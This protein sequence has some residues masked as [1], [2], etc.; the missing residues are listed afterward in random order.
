MGASTNGGLYKSGRSWRRSFQEGRVPHFADEPPSPPVPSSQSRPSESGPASSGAAAVSGASRRL[1][2]LADL[3]GSLTDALGPEEAAN[4]VEQK[5]LS[6]L[7]A[8]S[9]VVVTLGAF[10]PSPTTVPAHPALHVVHAIGLPA[11]IGA[12]LEQL[13]LDAPVPMAEVAREGK[14]LFLASERE[15]A[16]YPDWGVAM[17]TAGA[18]SA[19]IVPVWANG[20]LRG[21]LG[22]T[23][24]SPRVFDEDERAFVLTLGI[25]CAQSIMRAHLRAAEIVA[26]EAAERANQSKAHFVTT[27]S[28]ELRTPVNA[29]MGYADLMDNEVYGPVSTVQ[30]EHIARMRASGTHL[31]GLIEELLG[32]ARIEAGEEV[33]R[34]E[35]VLLA[36]V[37]EQS[38][39]L[40]QPLAQAK[41]LRIGV[42]GLD[43]PFEMFT[44][45]RKVR[46]ILV[47]VLAN[48]V[49]FTTVGDVVLLLRHDGR[50]AAVKMYFE[51]TDT[52]PGIATEDHEHVFDPF[53]QKDPRSLHSAGSSGLG[54]SVARQLARLLGGDVVIAEGALGQ[55]STFI[56]AIPARFAARP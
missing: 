56:V 1:R 43:Q 47:N 10:P 34:P 11:E 31:L 21:V 2:A 15:M 7:G 8:T 40:V 25:M 39:A 42:V 26:R 49:K 54:L 29:V 6:A 22:L 13:P 38:V 32:F 30:K 19:A 18:R 52:G 5:A 51:V 45:A 14:A 48:A 44:D 50:D 3:S 28:H 41:G 4:L 20:E 55:G 9:A 33:V 53:W 35:A 27:I 46:Q 37:V 17:R 24:S 23:W 36:D 12:A 16:R